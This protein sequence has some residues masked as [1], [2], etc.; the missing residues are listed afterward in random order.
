MLISPEE[1]KSRMNEYTDIVNYE[2][3][4][5]AYVF[6]LNKHSTQLRESGTPYFSHLLEVVKILLDLKMD[7]ETI[8]GGMLHDTLEDTNTTMRELIDQFGS[9]IAKLVN[10]VTKLSKFEGISLE[11]QQAENF[12]KLLMSAAADIRVLIIKLA[13]R[14]H[15]MRTLKHKRK[16]SRK[17]FIAKETLEIY[18]P[19]AERI[20]LDSIKEELQDLAFLELNP[21]AYDTI[22][23]RLQKLYESEKGLI[24]S[25]SETLCELAKSVDEDCIVSGRLK[26]PYSIW[27]KLNVRG[28][29][30]DQI[31]D[32]MAFRVIVKTIPQ[33]Y[34]V[35]GLIHKNYI[36][37]PK[38]FRD[39]ISTPKNNSYQSIHTSVIGPLSKRIE[40]QIRTKEM[41]DIAEHGIAAHWNYKSGSRGSDKNDKKDI[42]WINNLVKILESNLGIEQFIKDNQTEI[43]A[44]KVFCITP[45]GEIISLSKGASVLDFAYAI[46]SDVGN[47][48]VGAKI[49]GNPVL[50]NT[51]IDNGDQIE[52]ETDKNSFPKQV[53]NDFVVTTRAKIA[54]NKELNSFSK[55]HATIIGKGNFENFFQ[56][57]GIKISTTDIQLIAQYFNFSTENRLFYSIGTSSLIMQEVLDAYNKLKHTNI[58]LQNGLTGVVPPER[59]D[60]LPINGLPA[61]P[62]IRVSCC[63]AMPGDKIVGLIFQN[64]QVE[65]HLENCP[66]FAQKRNLIDQYVIPLSWKKEAYDYSKEYVVSLFI[67]LN[68]FSGILA[69]IADLIEKRDAR[70]S[71]LNITEQHNELTQLKLDIKVS[72]IAQLIMI[73]SDLRAHEAIR[74]VSRY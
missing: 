52:I 13:D 15:N 74:K 57:C 25:I 56:Q 34:Q 71:N 33:C 2:L 21:D 54:L 37:I 35:L 19:L 24:T 4:R 72:S 50:L 22:Y 62:L 38:R 43:G 53:W 67:I 32:I 9:K 58:T 16:Q 6:A 23:S 55:E 30:F 61:L 3:I 70:I 28:I 45:K 18:A 31:S 10:G 17:Q 59:E 26:K 39:Y 36:V 12:R 14:L 69:N 66:I 7:Q 49:N 48:A 8:I 73:I 27:Q 1:I 40:I 64:K 29:T 5:K 63:S 68:K 47:R 46:H 42:L 11:K 51:V 20:G 41:H 44:D 60:R 65:I